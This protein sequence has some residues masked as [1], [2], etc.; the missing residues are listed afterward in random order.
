MS[1]PGKPTRSWL[2]IGSLMVNMLLVGLIAGSAI[3]GRGGA[4]AREFQRSEI[5]LARGVLETA[6]RE[7][8]RRIGKLLG[9]ALREN[10]DLAIARVEARKTLAEALAREPYDEA[11]VRSAF[12]ALNEADRALQA[13]IQDTLAGEMGSLSREQ[14]EMLARSMSEPRMGRGPPRHLRPKPDPDGD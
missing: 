11:A 6:S 7:E 4:E 13:A 5:R 8:R 2:L 10:R 1:E 14:R 12:T 3:G 9:Q